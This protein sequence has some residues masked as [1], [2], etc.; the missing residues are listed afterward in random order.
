MPEKTQAFRAKSAKKKG[1]T[2]ALKATDVGA[3]EGMSTHRAK[4][5]GGKLMGD[6]AFDDRSVSPRKPPGRGL[7]AKSRKLPAPELGSSTSRV[8]TL[9]VEAAAG[10]RK[11]GTRKKTTGRGDVT[12]LKA[13][14]KLTRPSRKTGRH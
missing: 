6:V 2:M 14:K 3:A 5:K 4:K 7:T 8:K 12:P 10:Y 13:S 11:D 1:T 9:P